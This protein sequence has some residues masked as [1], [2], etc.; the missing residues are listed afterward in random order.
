MSF[1]SFASFTLVKNFKTAKNGV[2]CPRNGVKNSIHSF[3]TFIR[4]TFNNVK[5]LKI[6]V[7]FLVMGPFNKYVTVEGEGRG[8]QDP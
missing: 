6:E 4:S 3:M 2:F 7:H 1:R 5:A 8:S